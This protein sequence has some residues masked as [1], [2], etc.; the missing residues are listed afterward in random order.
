MVLHYDFEDISGYK[1]IDKSGT[2]NDGQIKGSLK[3]V[4]GKYGKGLLFDFKVANYIDVGE[5][6]FNGFNDKGSIEA[7]AKLAK[8]LPGPPVPSVIRKP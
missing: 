4:K 3:Q 6:F 5:L 1:V 8:V 7:W 2:G